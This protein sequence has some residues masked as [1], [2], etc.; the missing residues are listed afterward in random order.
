M[1]ANHILD[2][3]EMIDDAL[4]LEAR[5]PGSKMTAAGK[6]RVSLGRTLALA[7]ALA[8]LL[9]LCGFAAY[10]LGWLDLWLQRPAANPADT[11][12]S[13]IENQID[14]DYTIDVRIDEI[15]VDP[16]ETRRIVK[17]YSGSQL[18]KA[19]GWTDEYLANHFIV[20]WARY[21]VQ[22]DHTKTFLNDGCTEQYFYLT[23]DAETGIWTIVDNTSPNT[24]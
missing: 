23:Q 13:A 4:I 12:Q 3:L 24:Q 14:K 1:N 15:R 6:R 17:M 11:V 8:A 2:A 5:E 10:E 21:Y 22:Y 20:V 16:D 19:R 18:A 9:A 7:A